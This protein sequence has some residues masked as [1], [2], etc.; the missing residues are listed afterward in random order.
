MIAAIIL[1]RLDSKRFPEKALKKLGG[2]KLLE[3]PIRALI[4]G[5][6]FQP[7]IATSSR[8]T[9]DPLENLAKKYEIPIFRGELENVSRRII[10]CLKFYKISEF[11]RI[12]GDSPFVRIDLLEKGYN[13]LKE[14]NYDFVTNLYPRTFPYGISV[15][16]FNA[17]F[18]IKKMMNITDPLDREHATSYFYKNINQFKYKNISMDNKQNNQDIRLTIDIPKDLEHIQAMINLDKNIFQRNINQIISTYKQ[19]NNSQKYD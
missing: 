15:E 4:G 3:H 6:I 18:Y 14:N 7:I 2:I 8:K 11:A 10:D 16:I 1:T 19:I 5:G 12:N 17:N 9:D 13:L